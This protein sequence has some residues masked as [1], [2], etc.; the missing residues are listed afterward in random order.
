MSSQGRKIFNIDFL[1]FFFFLFYASLFII[2]ILFSFF[3]V[4]CFCHYTKPLPF[5]LLR[6]NGFNRVLTWELNQNHDPEVGSLPDP[7][8]RG[9]RSDIRF[10]A[11]HAKHLTIS[12]S[13]NQ[14]RNTMSSWSVRLY[15][16]WRR[17]SVLVCLF[18]FCRS[19]SRL[20]TPQSIVALA[21]PSCRKGSGRHIVKYTMTHLYLILFLIAPSGF[22]QMLLLIGTQ[23]HH[24]NEQ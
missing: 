18:V 3:F 9:L 14:S 5:G 21:N 19:L 10:R 8:N 23:P 12:P 1:F 24:F 6:G 22:A 7:T 13:V 17:M 11:D 20:V 4:F 16:C 15:I 2:Y